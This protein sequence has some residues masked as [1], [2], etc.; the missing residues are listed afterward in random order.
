MKN[1]SRTFNELIAF[2]FD[3]SLDAAEQ[4]G[5][6]LENRNADAA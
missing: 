3:N 2:V 5:L 4:S 6:F 1:Q